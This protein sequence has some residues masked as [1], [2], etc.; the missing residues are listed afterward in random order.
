[1]NKQLIIKWCKR[2]GITIAS[3]VAVFLLYILSLYMY[4]EYYIPHHI[5]SL[6]QEGLSN[7]NKAKAII[8]E[9]KDIESYS[10][11]NEYKYLQL[12]N[13]YADKNEL[14]AQILL[15]QY[16][17]ERGLT[18]NSKI[19]INKHIWGITLGKST[20]QD[21]W[22]Y[23]DS[24]GLWYQDYANENCIQSQNDFEFAGIYWNCIDYHFINNRVSAIVFRCRGD[25]SKLE[26]YYY[27]LRNMIAKKYTI[28]KTIKSSKDKEYVSQ[29][30]IKDSHTLIQIKLY[31]YSDNLS[32]YELYFKY[33]DLI[34]E[35]KKEVSNINDI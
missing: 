18:L 35:K 14:W 20:K 21:V 10:Y 8:S 32:K 28:S 15:E 9:L 16:N 6:Y 34:A 19:S 33:I 29:F 3:A 24:K 13:Y 5:E 25:E 27:N 26:E 17:E 12:I 22:N 30:S 1:M 11:S 2:A 23:L 4:E 7:P 31:N